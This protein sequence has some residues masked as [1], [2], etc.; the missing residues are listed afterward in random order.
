MGLALIN[1]LIDQRWDLHL[2]RLRESVSWG[3]GA[4][5]ETLARLTHGF[6]SLGSE[7]PLAA[8]AKLAQMVRREALVM[9][10]GDVFLALT[11]LFFAL[12]VVTPFMRRP[13][14]ATVAEAH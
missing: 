3:R 9:A 5:D 8:A 12:V 10:L 11:V 2:Q 7:A 4:A 13:A 14:S 1:T 6:S